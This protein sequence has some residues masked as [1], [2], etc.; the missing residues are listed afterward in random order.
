MVAQWVASLFSPVF[1]T[2]NVLASVQVNTQLFFR[3]RQDGY[4]IQWANTRSYNSYS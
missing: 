2:G 3:L 4:T 1:C